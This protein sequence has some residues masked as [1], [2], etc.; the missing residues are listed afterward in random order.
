VTTSV[1]PPRR[2][3]PRKP[4]H[5]VRN[6]SIGVIAIFVLLAA[7]GSAAS[8]RRNDVGPTVP[9][10]LASSDLASSD[11][12]PGSSEAGSPAPPG[13]TLLSMKGTGFKT[14]E[15]FAAGGDSVDVTYE[16]TCTDASSFTLNFYGTSSSPVLPEILASEFDTHGSSTTTE[17]LNGA[18]GPFTVEVDSPCEW[19]VEVV[20]TP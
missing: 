9:P 12:G 3:A 4:S 20:G 6:A 17:S 15:P 14:S 10:D 2:P 19:S 8:H 1:T 11:V 7:L 13:T 16:Y 5:W 18:A